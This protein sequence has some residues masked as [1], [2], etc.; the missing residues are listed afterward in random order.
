MS[1]R[2]RRSRGV[3]PPH[4]ALKNRAKMV[5]NIPACCDRSLLISHTLQA[6]PEILH[7]HVEYRIMWSKGGERIWSEPLM[8]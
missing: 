4:N 1:G 5:V 3:K 8:T 2:R 6:P 7:G